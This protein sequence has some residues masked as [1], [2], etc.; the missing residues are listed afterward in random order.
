MQ[1]S[2][3]TEAFLE[4]LTALSQK[5]GITIHACGCCESPWLNDDEKMEGHR[6]W[7]SS[8]CDGLTWH[9]RTPY[10]IRPMTSVEKAEVK[11][12]QDDVKLY[13]DWRKSRADILGDGL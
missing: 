1:T 2:P 3:K 7:V 4:E 8:K 6:Y 13:E 12:Q 5:Y 11:K 10:E 9:H